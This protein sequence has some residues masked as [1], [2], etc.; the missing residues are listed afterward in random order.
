[1]LIFTFGILQFGQCWRLIEA[2]VE[3]IKF[4][5]ERIIVTQQPTYGIH[6]AAKPSEHP[7]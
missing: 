5:K 3:F 1:M 4:I 6:Y 2:P 7:E